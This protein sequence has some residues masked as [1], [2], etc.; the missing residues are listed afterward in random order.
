MH[1]LA[2]RDLS[3]LTLPPV[4]L[5]HSII[6]ASLLPVLH[7]SRLHSCLRV[8]TPAIRSP[9]MFFLY[10]LMACHFTSFSHL[11]QYHFQRDVFSDHP[12]QV[13]SPR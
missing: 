8:I 4:L 12:T 1:N 11:F 5:A 9:G 3:G 2:C 6:V 13:V 10:M 7:K